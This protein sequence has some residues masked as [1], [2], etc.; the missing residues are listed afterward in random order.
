MILA[1]I[2]P[3]VLAVYIVMAVGFIVMVW[4]I[5]N[6]STKSNARI[7]MVL[8][9]LIVFGAV[10]ASFF[11]SGTKS[12]DA[13]LEKNARIFRSAKA[14]RA[15]AYI[16]ERFPDG[17]SAAFLIDDESNSDSGS[18]SYFI[19]QEL[20]SRLSEKGVSCGD[21]IIV[22]ELTTD[23]KTGEEK[24]EEPTDAAIMKKKLDQVYDRVDIVVNFAGLPS[25]TS[26]LK[27][28]TFL[29]KKNTATGKNNML[30]MC[31]NGLPYVEQDMLKSGRVCAIIDYISE[32]GSSF[33]MQ[34]NS[35]PKDLSEAFDFF[36][37]L[38]CPDTLESYIANNENYFITK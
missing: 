19:L 34:K 9:A 3:T 26:E 12:E 21:V 6:M 37:Y 20:Q 10:G 1:D 32:A 5:K 17:G 14:E 38:I 8:G 22:G 30:L 16:A 2:E 27:K 4:G 18:E 33:D 23:K 25:S 35:A 31:D 15:A 36:Y 24:R 29:T 7:F 11:V 13:R 28:I